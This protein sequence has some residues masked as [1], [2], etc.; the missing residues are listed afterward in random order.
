[1]SQQ[2]TR[3]ARVIDPI[4]TTHA[5]GY[6]R[7]G[8]INQFLFP[9]AYVGVY[10]GQVLEFN[11][12]SFRRYNTKR[13][14]GSATKR[15]QFGYAGKPYAIVPNAL[16]AL[17][18]YELMNDAAQVPGVDLASDAVDGVLDV[19]DLSHECEA[20]DLARDATKYDANHK[21]ALVGADRWTGANGDP[22]KNIVEAVEAIR[23]SVGVR[24][25]TVALSASAFT[26]L[27]FNAKILDRLKYTSAG[28][29]TTEML[30][31]LWNVKDVVVG[32][33]VVASGQD[34][35]FGD[36]WGDDVIVAYVAKPIGGNK[37]S[38]AR[39][40]Y[41]YTYTMKGHPLV[42][43]PYQDENHLSWVYP[44]SADRTPVLS[45]ITA[46]FLLQNAGG[47]SS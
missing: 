5:Q 31:R 44:T 29:V 16:E 42:R 34:D 9:V 15:I 4:L 11:K 26:A 14:P 30:A 45:G 1:M 35:D 7:P 28:A 10:G 47:P 20:A 38:N 12:E 19:M 13:A 24:A 21:L 18:P 37:R 33:A 22:T 39:P 17:V 27:Q 3:Q 41:G 40:S 46:G 6:V 25:N 2:T 36:V 32:D 43:A 23:S 8:N